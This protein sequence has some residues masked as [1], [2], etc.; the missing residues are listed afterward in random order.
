MTDRFRFR[1][2]RPWAGIV[3]AADR[4]WFVLN[5]YPGIIIGLVVG[6]PKLGQRPGYPMLSILW[7]RPDGTAHRR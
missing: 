2:R 6:L 3:R 5:R 4:H 7:G 1:W